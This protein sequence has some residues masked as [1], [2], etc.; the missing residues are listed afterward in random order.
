MR[1]NILTAAAATAFAA[2]L[3]LAAPASAAVNFD[4]ASGGFAGKGDVQ[5][6]FGWSNSQLQTSA[7]GVSF[8]EVSETVTQRTWECTNP[9]NLKENQRA[10]TTTASSSAVVSS[11]VRDKS[12]QVTGFILGASGTSSGTSVTDGPA[13]N[14]CPNGWVLTQSAGDPEQLSKTSEL[15]VAH[16][17]YNAGTPVTLLALS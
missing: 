13:L 17:S 1:K 2:S 10:R 3:A 14:S 4:P 12:K 7:S 16:S 5:L 8:A 15:T 6:A 11:A 9:N